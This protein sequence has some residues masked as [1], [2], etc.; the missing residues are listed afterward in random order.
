MSDIASIKTEKVK[1]PFCQV[2]EVEVT[3][4]SEYYSYTHARAF[5]KVKAIPLYHPEQ[6]K[7]ESKCPN[8]KASKSDI[9]EALERGSGKKQSHEAV[10][11]R[12][13]DSGLPLIIG[14]V[15]KEGPKQ[16][17]TKFNE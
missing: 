12:F 1:C 13:K 17:N 4:K 9:K 5:G 15:K 16:E 6:I 8:C 3:T 2:G 11:K 10:L 14:S 7:I